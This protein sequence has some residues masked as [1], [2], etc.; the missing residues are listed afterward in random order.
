MPPRRSCSGC[1]TPSRPRPC[2][3][4]PGGRYWDVGVRENN[5]FSITNPESRTVGLSINEAGVVRM[6][7][8]QL[9]DK[10]QVVGFHGAQ[11]VQTP[12]GVR[13]AG[14]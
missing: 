13:R 4:G 1:G 9:G 6:N 11:V 10:A 7:V 5:L 12:Q 2:S 3:G 14:G 8:L